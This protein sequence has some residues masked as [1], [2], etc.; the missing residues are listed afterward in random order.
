MLA[1]KLIKQTIEKY[2]KTNEIKSWFFGKVNRIGK[3]LAK[4]I[5]KKTEDKALKSGLKRGYYY[6]CYR[7]K[8]NSKGIL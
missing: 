3:P 2:R 8:K 7:N 1:W 4:L 5:K 6:L